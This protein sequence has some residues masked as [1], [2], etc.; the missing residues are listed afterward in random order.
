V[1]AE[2]DPPAPPVA[3]AVAELWIELSSLPLAKAG[4][5]KRNTHIIAHKILTIFL[6]SYEFYLP[7]FKA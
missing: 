3:V 2:D 5:H 4:P 7:P 1:T 6:P